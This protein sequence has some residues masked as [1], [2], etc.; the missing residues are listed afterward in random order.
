LSAALGRIVLLV[1]E[2]PTTEGLKM[3]LI[4]KCPK[5][6]ATPQFDNASNDVIVYQRSHC[7]DCIAEITGKAVA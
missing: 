5:C 4:A 2:T 1:A 3:L 6:Q 7:P